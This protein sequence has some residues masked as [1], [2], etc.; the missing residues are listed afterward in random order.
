MF[1]GYKDLSDMLYYIK[2][3]KFKLLYDDSFFTYH[4]SIILINEKDNSEKELV[5]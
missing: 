4:L 1:K 2:N 5:L 3:G